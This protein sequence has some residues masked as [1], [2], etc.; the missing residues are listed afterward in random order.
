MLCFSARVFIIGGIPGSPRLPQVAPFQGLQGR[1]VCG[2]HSFL[3][4]RTAIRTTVML[5]DSRSESMWYFLLILPKREWFRVGKLVFI[6]FSPPSQRDGWFEAFAP[7][8]SWNL[9]LLNGDQSRFL[10]TQLYIF[11]LGFGFPSLRLCV[12]TNHQ[13]LWYGLYM[14]TWKRSLWNLASASLKN[15]KLYHANF[16]FLGLL[17]TISPLM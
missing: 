15:I 9:C 13:S 16:D 17:K 5:V 14:K 8:V 1:S 11:S 6:I 3:S 7:F 2:Y 4:H 12:L 10:C